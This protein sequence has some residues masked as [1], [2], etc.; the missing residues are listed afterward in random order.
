MVFFC[1]MTNYHKSNSFKQHTLLSHSCYESRA[2]AE[3]SKSSSWGLT[4]LPSRCWPG[5]VP[6]CRL[7]QARIHSHVH[8]RRVHLLASVELKTIMG[9]RLEANLSFKNLSQFLEATHSSLPHGIPQ[10][11]CFFPQANKDP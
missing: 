4:R 3:L 1:C 8:L 5:C 9:W 10:H 11:C 2:H 7:Y 6:M